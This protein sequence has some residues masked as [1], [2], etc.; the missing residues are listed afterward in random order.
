MHAPYFPSVIED[1]H[2][3]FIQDPYYA[4]IARKVCIISNG[5]TKLSPLSCD[6]VIWTNDGR[7]IHISVR[8]NCV[9]P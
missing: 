7:K 4:L 1:R 9:T 2:L 8:N 5:N 3:C 6:E